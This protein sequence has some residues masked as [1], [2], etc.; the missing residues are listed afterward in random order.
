MH[1]YEI[2]TDLILGAFIGCSY[3]FKKKGL[4]NAQRKG[5]RS[6]NVIPFANRRR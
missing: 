6:C 4:L 1:S 3:V 2:D 5:N